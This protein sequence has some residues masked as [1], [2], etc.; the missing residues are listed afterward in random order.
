MSQGILQT[1]KHIKINEKILWETWS[2]WR[3]MSVPENAWP[4]KWVNKWVVNQILVQWVGQ[5][6]SHSEPVSKQASQWMSQ[7]FNERGGERQL[8]SGW[9]CE[10]KA[11]LPG[12]ITNWVKALVGQWVNH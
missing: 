5:W 4:Y 3:T 8:G 2:S 11:R 12:G 7:Y 9:V 10:K 6:F 1:K